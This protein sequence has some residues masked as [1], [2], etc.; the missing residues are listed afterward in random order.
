ME[1]ADYEAGICGRLPEA[2]AIPFRPVVMA[3][4]RPRISECH[5]NVD[6]WVAA[7]PDCT[8]VRGWGTYLDQG[9]LGVKLTAHSVVRAPDHMLFDIT[10]L[11]DERI[12]PFMRFVSHTGDDKSFVIERSRDLFITCPCSGEVVR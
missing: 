6:A 1:R 4:G 10:P 11:A 12:R 9:L 7:H 8:A 2:E 5:Q 3:D